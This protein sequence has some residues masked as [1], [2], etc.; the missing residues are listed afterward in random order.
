MSPVKHCEGHVLLRQWPWQWGIVCIYV[1][2]CVCVC[3]HVCVC[4][5]ESNRDAANVGDSG[6][7]VVV[8]CMYVCVRARV[9]ACAYM[10]LRSRSFICVHLLTHI[11][12]LLSAGPREGRNASGCGRHHQRPLGPVG[13]DGRKGTAEIL[14]LLSLIFVFLPQ[15]ANALHLDACPCVRPTP[16]TPYPRLFC[17]CLFCFV[18]VVSGG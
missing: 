5:C 7:G 9:R 14:T 3:V 13:Q 12:S 17:C 15:Q 16:H 10:H 18:I 4:V 1:C 8:V 2:V 11:F 6:G